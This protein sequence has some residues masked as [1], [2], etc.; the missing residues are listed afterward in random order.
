MNTSDWI[1]RNV[2][3]LLP[4]TA[5]KNIMAIALAKST[6]AATNKEASTDAMAGAAGASQAVVVPARVAVNASARQVSRS[7]RERLAA[8][9][10][11]GSEALSPRELRRTLA[12]L[13]AVVDSHV[14]EVEGGLRAKAVARWYAAAIP[15]QRH[16]CWLLMSEQ[17]VADPHVVQL[18]QARFAGAVGTADEAAAEVQYRRA[19]V[20]PRRRLLQRFSAFPE[21]IRFLVDMRAEMLAHLKSDK[22][23]QALDVEMEYMF[24]TWFDVGFLDLRRISWDSPA[25]LIEKLIKYEAVH[26]IKGWA[27]VK[28]RLDSDRRCYG[29]FHPRLPDDPLIFVEVAL[30]DVMAASI[31]PLLDESADATDLSKA[32]TAIFYSIS[33]TQ[34]GL[35]GVS[36]GDSLI[37]RVV[38]ALKAEFPR[39]KTFATLSPIPGFRA[40]LGKNA[41]AMLDKLSDKARAELGH[42]LGVDT[43]TALHLLSAADKALEFDAK[44]AVRHVLLQ[45]A[46]H[47]LSREWV[48]GKPYDPVARFHLGNGARIERLNWGGDPCA[49]GLK[50]SCGMM[51]NYLYDPSRLDKYRAQ[52]AQGKIPV[53]GAI[54]DL[55]F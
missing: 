44:S 43:V 27:D 47:Y 42:A 31:T 3:R 54:G 23:L 20:S 49:K 38:E 45:C 30:M 12:E 13:Q 17:F 9:L 50:Q 25:S 8:I 41:A 21:G 34:P 32:T 28:N 29:F 46:A 7:T 55:N 36:F 39:L 11:R 51:V 2:S 18:A 14:S 35:R 26:D 22:R 52:L 6:Q 19:T 4:A 10:R 53:S 15:A 37:K 48:E 24:S 16:D 5:S 1:S 40:W 33:N